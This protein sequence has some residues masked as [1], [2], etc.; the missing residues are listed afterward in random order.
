MWN[1]RKRSRTRVSC[2]RVAYIHRDTM[3]ER[4]R[5]KRFIKSIIP[6]SRIVS[7][8]R[9]S[10]LVP[11]SKDLSGGAVVEGGA[12]GGATVV[13]GGATVEVVVSGNAR[14]CRRCSS[15]VQAEGRKKQTILTRVTLLEWDNCK[16]RMIT[17]RVIVLSTHCQKSRKIDFELTPMVVIRSEAGFRYK[18]WRESETGAAWHTVAIS[19]AAIN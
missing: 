2:R 3:L 9:D 14:Y 17:V 18:L 8:G 15:S 10:L 16:S 12:S 19:I 6:E 7:V 4:K 1:T 13:V 11:D 5:G